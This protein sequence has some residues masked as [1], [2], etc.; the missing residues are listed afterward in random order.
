MSR[1]TEIALVT[2][3]SRTNP[4][5]SSLFI[6]LCCVSAPPFIGAI[7]AVITMIPIN[8]IIKQ[9]G[10]QTQLMT[11]CNPAGP[12]FVSVFRCILF[13]FVLYRSNITQLKLYIIVHIN[14]YTIYINIFK[15]FRSCASIIT[16]NRQKATRKR[17]WSA[18]FFLHL[19]CFACRLIDAPRW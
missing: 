16:L 18:S 1:I 12:Q 4:S 5:S 19:I 14:L 3:C 6:S 17:T 15:P 10:R 13:C 2:N 9:S 7:I 8:P 11:I